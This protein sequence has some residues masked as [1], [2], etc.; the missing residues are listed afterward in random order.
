MEYFKEEPR[1]LDMEDWHQGHLQDYNPPCGTTACFAG[2]TCIKFKTARQSHYDS[3]YYLPPISGWGE[4]AAKILGLTDS[5]A[6]RLFR[7]DSGATRLVETVK[8]TKNI[9]PKRYANAYGKATTP[10]GRFK[11]FLNRVN[12]FLKTK[13]AE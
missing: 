2:A 6:D 12:H 9:W 5:Q 8:D 11:V 10:A 7:L 1:R 4:S 3:S 13:G